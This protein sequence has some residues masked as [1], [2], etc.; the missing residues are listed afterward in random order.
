MSE[1]KK[2]LF[3]APYGGWFPHNQVDAI[4]ASALRLRNC[5]VCI[6]RC[7][8]IYKYCEV[9]ALSGEKAK[10][11]CNDCSRGG[12]R[13]FDMF[14][15]PCKEL[16][17]YI[18]EE[19]K[20]EI[21]IWLEK[22]EPADYFTSEYKGVPIGKWTLSS[23]LTYFHTTPKGLSRIKTGDVPKEILRNG[24]LTFEGMTK[25]LDKF[26]PSKIVMFNARMAPY[27]VAFELGRMRNIDTVVHERGFSDDNFILY[28][29]KI[30][31]SNK[32]FLK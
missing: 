5:Q 4:I 30:C 2:I 23:V 31:I 9:V 18:T 26:N 15:L 1:L 10:K 28:E 14:K 20:K 21:N 12:K 29:N 17:P 8:G 6:V 16:R 27:R 32:L 19:D 11:D 24:L 3:F 25:I 13:F 22:L 7:D